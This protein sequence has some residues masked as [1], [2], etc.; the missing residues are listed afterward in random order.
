MSLPVM[1]KP[2]QTGAASAQ[3]ALWAPSASLESGTELTWG[4]VASPLNGTYCF[5]LVPQVH[6]LTSGN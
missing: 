1:A 6:F 5:K 4:H 3:A 2:P